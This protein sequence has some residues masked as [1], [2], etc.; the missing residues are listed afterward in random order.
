M[1][2]WKMCW[3]GKK[4]AIGAR[5]VNLDEVLLD[6]MLRPTLASTCTKHPLDYSARD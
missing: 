3:R 2:T 5:A 1:E 4:P 6:Q